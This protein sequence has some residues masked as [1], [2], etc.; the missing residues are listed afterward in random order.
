M[1][2][3]AMNLTTIDTLAFSKRM[4]KIDLVRKEI[5]LS[6]QEVIIRTGRSIYVAT[7]LI[8]TVISI[9]VAFLKF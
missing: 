7:A 2:T 3:I 9:S 4:Q 5:E 1:S 8:I 6:K